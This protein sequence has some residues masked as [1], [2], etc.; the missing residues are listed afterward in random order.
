MYDGR[1][2]GLIDRFNVELKKKK[3]DRDNSVVLGSV[4]GMKITL[5]EI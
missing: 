4:T 1:T 2:Q 3:R 5:N